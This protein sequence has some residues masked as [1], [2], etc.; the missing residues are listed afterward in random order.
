MTLVTWVRNSYAI[1][2]SYVV[3]EAFDYVVSFAR[4]VHHVVVSLVQAFVSFDFGLSVFVVGVFVAL[5]HGAV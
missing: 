4:S 2:Y 3:T 5:F 1:D